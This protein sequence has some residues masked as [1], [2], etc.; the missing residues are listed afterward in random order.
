MKRATVRTEAGE[1]LGISFEEVGFHGFMWLDA[2]GRE[3]AISDDVA[4]CED[5]TYGAVTERW[6]PMMRHL[7]DAERR[8]CARGA[9]ATPEA[10]RAL[11][12]ELEGGA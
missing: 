12:R 6:A 3:W 7:A 1:L 2:H 8:L 10:V 9:V 4:R 11:A 5:G